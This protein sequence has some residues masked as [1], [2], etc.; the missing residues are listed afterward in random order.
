MALAL[1]QRPQRSG[2][3]DGADQG[4]ERRDRWA[5]LIRHGEAEGMLPHGM[6]EGPV[7][8]AAVLF[9][10]GPG[11]FAERANG[12]ANV[13]G[14]GFWRKRSP[15]GDGH[16]IGNALRYFREKLSPIEAEDTAPDA[17][18]MNGNDGG[19]SAFHDPFESPAK[20]EEGAGS[21]DLAF[22]K[23][24]DDLAFVERFSCFA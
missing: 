18:Q 9:A 11:R 17:I 12:A 24:A 23:D 20:G 21:G 16:G 8:R 19:A 10:E 6:D 22:R 1:P 15:E 14:R 2:E 4:L 7:Q 5:G 13:M 3:H